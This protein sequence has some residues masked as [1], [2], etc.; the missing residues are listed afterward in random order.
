M[1]I[2]ECPWYTNTANKTYVK[3]F[4]FTTDKC[5]LSVMRQVKNFLWSPMIITLLRK[6]I[7]FLIMLSI[8]TGGIFSPLDVMI[9]SGVERKLGVFF[10]LFF[11]FFFF[12]FLGGGG[13]LIQLP[14]N[15]Y[16]RISNLVTEGYVVPSPLIR[17]VM[18][19]NP[20][21]SAFLVG[22]TLEIR[23]GQSCD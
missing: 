5:T 18:Y 8:G 2:D 1:N 4:C 17:P 6:G 14:N 7:S 11:F 22:N 21:Y 20:S 13:G 23:M 3:D 12:F 16:T 15:A 10:S 19:R 9:S